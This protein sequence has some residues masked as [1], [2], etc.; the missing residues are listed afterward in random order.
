MVSSLDPKEI[1]RL[2]DRLFE[3]NS[4]NSVKTEQLTGTPQNTGGG[5]LSRL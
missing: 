1:S 2:L 5:G 4:V 3:V